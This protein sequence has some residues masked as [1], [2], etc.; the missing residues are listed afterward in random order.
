MN[1]IR[2]DLDRMVRMGPL[3]GVVTDEKFIP[4]IKPLRECPENEVELYAN[5]KG[6]EFKSGRCPYS[7]EAFRGTIRGMVNGIEE[8]HPGSKFQILRS[9]DELIKKLRGKRFGR[10]EKI[11]RCRICGD[12]TSGETCRFCEIRGELGFG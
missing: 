10:I 8:K 6:L 7:K 5:L 9:T 3:V 4:R 11:G 1:F 2:G 12:P